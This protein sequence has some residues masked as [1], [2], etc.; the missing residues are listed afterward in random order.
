M[1][2]IFA[3]LGVY[4]IFFISGV[5]QAAPSPAPALHKESRIPTPA[6][7]EESRGHEQMPVMHLRAVLAPDMKPL[8]SGVKWRV[9]TPPSTTTTPSLIATSDDS[10]PRFF[11][12]PGPYIIHATFG[13]ASTIK[14]IELSRSV[15]ESLVIHAGVLR[16]IG[17]NMGTEIPESRITFAVYVPYD[18]NPE[19]R[20]LLRGI[21]PNTL[22]RL[23]EGTYHI[24]S[25]YGNANSILTADRKIKS[26]T[27]TDVAFNHHAATITFKLVRSPG[28]EA[29]AET[30]F[31]VLT[32]GGDPISIL[33]PG[34]KVS[35]RETTGAF[36]SLTLA[37]GRYV[38]VARHEG[39]TYTQEFSVKNGVNQDVEVLARESQSH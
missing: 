25:T 16:M 2:S 7:N 22:I 18:N 37:E 28:G 27:V 24:V 21:K 19:G 39:Q 14:N 12:K 5:V 20:L 9:F 33:A 32:P 26:D 15:V 10:E 6:P 17:K 38:V 30:T 11:L 35:K 3:A 8:T 36:P 31:S 1:Q 34:N 13:F 23:P 4:L 29:F